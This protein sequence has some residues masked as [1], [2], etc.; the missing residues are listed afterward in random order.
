MVL[1]LSASAFAERPDSFEPYPK[2]RCAFAKASVRWT[3]KLYLAEYGSRSFRVG[4]TH[5]ADLL[6]VPD[7]SQLN[8]RL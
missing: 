8:L 6:G 2:R 1:C 7:E 3:A 4:L 5:F